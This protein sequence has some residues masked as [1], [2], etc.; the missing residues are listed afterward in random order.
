MAPDHVKNITSF[1]VICD[2]FHEPLTGGD[3][4]QHPAIV[5]DHDRGRL[6]NVTIR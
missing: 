4:G 3:M 6:I 1:G 2:I 5:S